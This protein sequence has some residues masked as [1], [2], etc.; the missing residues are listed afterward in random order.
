MTKRSISTILRKLARRYGANT[1]RRWHYDDPPPWI[2]SLRDHSL[3]DRVRTFGTWAGYAPEL[4][5]FKAQRFVY[6]LPSLP[7]WLAR[8]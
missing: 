3:R 2:M 6:R 7:G 1:L 5:R 8:A 4:R